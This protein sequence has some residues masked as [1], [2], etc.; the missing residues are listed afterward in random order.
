M[1]S[2]LNLRYLIYL[3]PLLLVTGPFL[4]DLTISILSLLFLIYLLLHKNLKFLN[5][6]YFIL[7]LIFWIFITVNSFFSASL[8]SIKSS[9]TYLRFGVFLMVFFYFYKK[10][11]DLIL[12][13][14]RMIL[15]TLIIIS[16]DAFIQFFLGQNILGYPKDSRISS[17]FG[18]EKILG[19][20]LIKIVPIYISLYYFL[21]KKI[22]F[23][24]HIF[25]I[26]LF[27]LILII[28][29]AER[30]SLGLF[31][32]YCFLLSFMFYDNK[33]YILLVLSVLLILITSATFSKKVYSRFILQVK[34]QILVPNNADS[35]IS[36][37]NDFYYFTEAHDALYRTAFNMFKD[38]PL[39]GHGTKNFRLKCKD[40]KYSYSKKYSHSDNWLSCNTHPHN[41]YIQMLAENWILGFLFLIL[42]YIHFLFLFVKNLF[43]KKEKKILN[44][45]IISNLVFLWPIVPH[46]NFFHNWISILLY[47]NLSIFICMSNYFRKSTD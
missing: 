41:Y 7:F 15:I 26:L 19:S 20:F 17:F 13:L 46:G 21:K 12:N 29:S 8:I 24:Y 25:F 22:I 36:K 28:L 37:K 40:D 35:A 3:L 2:F 47:L 44:F 45:I 9:T 34:N 33:K 30:S 42:I 18:D 43:V 1:V 39:N 5:K 23:D 38:K 4:P 27:C 14:K 11:K 32:L 6:Y 31:L 16:L 10:D